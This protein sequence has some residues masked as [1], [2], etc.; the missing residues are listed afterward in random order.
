MYVQVYAPVIVIPVSIVQFFPTSDGS[1]ESEPGL[2][3][4]QEEP[5]KDSDEPDSDH[6]HTTPP[7][8]RRKH[9]RTSPYRMSSV[10]KLEYN[11]SHPIY[12]KVQDLILKYVLMWALPSGSQR[13]GVALEGVSSSPASTPTF[14]RRSGLSVNSAELMREMWFTNRDNVSLLLE[15]CRVGFRTPLSQAPT[16]RKLSDL[17][18]HWEQ[19]RPSVL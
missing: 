10:I 1:S 5:L 8:S 13:G 4:V 9:G 14:S 16:L 11:T 18:F 7:V 15:I 6:T 2:Q 19:V 3:S 17:Y 12:G